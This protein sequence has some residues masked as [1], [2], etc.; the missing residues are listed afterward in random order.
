MHQSIKAFLCLSTILFVAIVVVACKGPSERTSTNTLVVGLQSGYPP[1]DFRDKEGNIVGFD[2]DVAHLL[3]KKLGKEVV[4]KDMEFDALILALKQGKIDLI[5]SGMNITPPRRKEI[6]MVPYHG[7]TMTSLSL[8]FWKQIPPGVHSLED[9][10]KLPNATISVE[11]ATVSEQFLGK[12][13]DLQI[14]A[15]GDSLAPLMD[16]KYGKSMAN[17]V[18]SDVAN[19]LQKWHAEVNILPVPLTEEEQVHGFGIGINKQ[20]EPLYQQISQAI[21]ELRASGELAATETVW[22]QEGQ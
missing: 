18:E 21:E 10:I 17:L 5:I 19:F 11:L 1:F 15:F 3:G 20:N 12:F 8:V 4:L 2:I 9:L 14:R 22:F 6:F 13:K 7:A 16:V